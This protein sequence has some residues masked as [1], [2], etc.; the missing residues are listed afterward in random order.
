M[1]SI[2]AFLSLVICNQSQAIQC[3]NL[4]PLNQ[5]KL[6]DT[7]IVAE[8]LMR[9]FS[10]ITIQDE[11]NI[12]GAWDLDSRTMYVNQSR[13]MPQE[14]ILAHEL[15][16]LTTDLKVEKSPSLRN[17]ARTI[18]FK[19]YESSDGL[20]AR[21]PY[22]IIP[23]GYNRN[24]GFDEVHAL[25]K[26]IRVNLVIAKRLKNENDPRYFDFLTF[27]RKLKRQIFQFITASNFLLRQALSYLESGSGTISML[28]EKRENLIIQNQSAETQ[29]KDEVLYD[30]WV[31]IPGLKGAPEMVLNLAYYWPDTPENTPLNSTNYLTD[32]IRQALSDNIKLSESARSL[33]SINP[34]DF[35][36]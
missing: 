19:A 1:K 2:L 8:A 6:M 26:E 14:S 24:L 35:K 5:K 29:F 36:F 7:K 4:L 30:V 3:K 13:T 33:K 25:I 12:L 23:S 18:S 31:I 27:N 20:N 28:Y 21:L 32:I 11:P 15:T 16:H 22:N 17:F 10:V 9:N 34:E